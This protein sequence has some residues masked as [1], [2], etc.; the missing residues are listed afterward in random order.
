MDLFRRNTENRGNIIRIMGIFMI[1]LAALNVTEKI[2]CRHVIIVFF[3]AGIVCFS[4]HKMCMFSIPLKEKILLFVYTLILSM[5][6]AA[7][8]QVHYV[9][10]RSSMYEN[11]IDLD[12]SSVFTGMSLA[13]LLLPIVFIVIEFIK[14][15][16]VKVSE[17]PSDFNW[18]FF[19]VSW[20]IIYLAWIP[21]LLTFFQ[22]GIVG[23]G[24]LTLEMSMQSGIPDHNHWVVFYILILRFFL[25]VGKFISADINVGIFLYALTESLLSS[26]V[27]AAVVTEIRKKGISVK[28]CSVAVCIYALSGF[29]ASY[30]MTL[31]KDGIFSAGIILLALLLWE[32]P[33]NEKPALAYCTKYLLV[34][35]FIC[36]CRNNGIYVL[37]LCITGM[38]LLLKG[39]SK[40]LIEMGL[41]AVIISGII[42]GPVYD[43]LGIEKDSFV[44]SI[45]VPL[46]QIA[47]VVNEGEELTEYQSEVIY[48]LIP[49]QVWIENYCPT[50]SD[51]LKSAIDTVYLE[52]H[53]GDFFK[54]WFQLMIPNI[55]TYIRAYLMQMLGF[56]QTGVFHGN[57]YDYWLGVDDLFQRGY[58]ER[59]LIFEF[60]GVSIKPLLLSKM[61]FV[62]SGSMVWLLLFA[63]AAV[64][65]QSNSKRRLLVLLPF[66]A[67]WMIIMAAAPIAYAYRYIVMLPM[68]FPIIFSMPFINDAGDDNENGQHFSNTLLR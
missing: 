63:V 48:S 47:A 29:F 65:C 13:I 6:V 46:Q 2:G 45:S 33:M 50:L 11:Y 12:F 55:A 35:F 4:Y 36:F 59:D 27:C 64:W 39:S 9:E 1:I 14:R 28:F 57:Y 26:A 60:T 56:W 49:K 32:F 54:V 19:L 22:A 25:W 62:S 10:M 38:F 41:V 61:Q 3:I 17:H 42:Q 58:T 40:V 15:H 34:L 30:S 66:V 18:K 20:V 5:S 67:C 68:A 43:M 8:I 24:A 7:G 52:R 44:E 53:T 16:P 23:D 31:W 21:Y 37:V 51:D